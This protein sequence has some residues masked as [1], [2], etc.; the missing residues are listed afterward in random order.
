MNDMYYG[1]LD[2]T[3]D[4]TMLYTICLALLVSVSSTLESLECVL[5]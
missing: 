4:L 5:P 1:R 3:G 2:Y